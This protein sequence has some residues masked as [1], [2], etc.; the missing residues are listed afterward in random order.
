MAS[1]D[2]G[3]L[4]EGIKSANHI[5]DQMKQSVLVN[6]LRRVRLTIATHI[7]S[8]G[9]KTCGRQRLELMALGVPEFREPVAEQHQRTFPLF[10][11]MHLNPVCLDKA[12]F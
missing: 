9:V 11:Q 6:R 2:R 8:H 1:D 5:S 7:R 12:M 3:F 10:G 4:V